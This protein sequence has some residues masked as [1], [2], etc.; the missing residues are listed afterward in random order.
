MIKKKIFSSLLSFLLF[1]SVH[2]ASKVNAFST[3]NYCSRKNLCYSI[4]FEDSSFLIFEGWFKKDVIKIYAG[5]KLIFSNKITTE[6][7]TG[8]AM[9]YSLIKNKNIILLVNKIRIRLRM[10]DTK[11]CLIEKH[12]NVFVVTYTN[13]LQKYM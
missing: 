3:L 11:Y 13:Q 2:G 4:Q 5:H 12:K 9:I 6:E 10:N 1:L 8:L 7:S